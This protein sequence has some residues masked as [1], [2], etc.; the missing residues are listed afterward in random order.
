[1]ALVAVAGA[2]VAL[3]F[4]GWRVTVA[5]PLVAF[6]ALVVAGLVYGLL[7]V[8]VGS[9]LPRELEGSIVLVILA[10]LDNALSSG[11]FPIIASVPIPVVGDLAVTDLVPLYHPHELYATAVLDGDLATGH[12]APIGAWL[13]ALLVVAFLAYGRSTDTGLP[14]FREGRHEPR[15]DRR[16]DRRH[17]TPILV[18]LLVLAPAYAIYVFTLVAP[19]GPAVIHV[20]DATLRTT[21]P[22][23]FPACTTPMT[24][25]LLAGIAGLFLMDTAATADARLVVAGYRPT[26]SSWPARGS[27]PPSRSSPP[28]SRPR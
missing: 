23:A 25:A 12:I 26:R 6:G 10:D 27:W 28:V 11:L 15:R 8:I 22:A 13:A 17:R 3:L 5:A 4:I 9:L 14:R 1:M 19:D 18:A 24:A 2:A 21:L 20:G 16:P 7:G